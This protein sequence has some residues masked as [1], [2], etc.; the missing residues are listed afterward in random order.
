MVSRTRESQ[1]DKLRKR[2]S[3]DLDNIVLMAMRKEPNRR[4]ASVSQLAEDIRRHLVGLPVIA[5]EDTFGYR[6]SKFV[7]R[8]KAGVAAATLVAIALIGGMLTT[9]WQ[10][11][12]A[13]RRF[14]DVRKLANS[15]L[16]EFH[17]AI[18]KLPGATPARALVVKRALE[19]LDSLAQEAAGDTTLQS[20]LATAYEKVGH[21]QGNPYSANLGDIEG[22]LQSYQKSLAI[23]QALLKA[24]EQSTP[25]RLELAGSHRRL[26]DM[27]T[28]KNDL[29]TALQ[30]AR[31][32]LQLIEA[33]PAPEL[34]TVQARR[35]QAG[36][37]E[38]IGEVLKAQGD[39]A[40]SLEQQRRALQIME[41]LV[42]QEPA[43]LVVRRQLAIVVGK[44]GERLSAN[45]AAAEGVESARKALVIFTELVTA[46]PGNTQ[47]QRELGVAHNQLGDLFYEVGDVKNELA[48]YRQSL[49][50]REELAAADPTNQQ[51]RRDLAV[52][53]GNVGYAMAQMGDEAGM[54]EHYNK[55]IA[56]FEAM[57]AA[58]PSDAFLMRDLAA[59]YD[60]YAGSW[61]NLAELPASS[62]TQR[63]LRWQQARHWWERS[64]KLAEQM[65]ARGLLPGQEAGLVE[66]L[67]Q[68]LSECDSTIAKLKGGAAAKK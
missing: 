60:F 1:P 66:N 67:K 31:Q 48:H 51:L 54:V 49:Q 47:A 22:A 34:A 4:Y 59:G 42:A 36:A 63:L 57:S 56:T 55:S 7:T 21:I 11:R 24:N 40:A 58:K 16:F 44:V 33:L 39:K 25:L 41:T 35:E 15:F 45:G 8:H 52:S 27:L 3:G 20:E 53:Q 17:D 37:Y 6:A 10:A 5:R 64:L 18:E 61:R 23:R 12:K 46:Q 32:A 9:L 68:L 50:L 29:T 19:Y 13:E 38:S 30:H 28:Q 65:Q 43:N 26:S 62:S 2:L 14:N